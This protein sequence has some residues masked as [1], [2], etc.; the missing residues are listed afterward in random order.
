MI[1]IFNKKIDDLDPIKVRNH[2]ILSL[3]TLV[4]SVTK[5]FVLIDG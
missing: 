3:H 1:Y 2:E 5:S 4:N